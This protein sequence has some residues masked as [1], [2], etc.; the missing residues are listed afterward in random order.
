MNR[1]E[2]VETNGENHVAGW[3]QSA[4]GVRLWIDINGRG[5]PILLIH[6][7]TMSSIFWRRQERLANLF[8]LISIDMRGHGRSQSILRGHTVSRYARDVREVITTL[9]LDDAMLVGWSMGGSVVA[10]YWQQYGNDRVS[11]IGLVETCPYPMSSA[12]WNTHRYQ[13]QNLD[14]MRN[15]LAR[16]ALD[17]KTFGTNFINNMFLSGLAP[18]HALKWMQSEHLKVTDHTASSIYEDYAQ[19]DYTA[20]L[21]TITVPSLVIYGRSRHFCLGPSTGRFVA[22][23]IP[24]SRLVI[25]EKSGHLPFY[26]E[27]DAFN[28]ELIHFLN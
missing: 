13:G 17:R 26:E 25:L 3:V 1:F 20:V 19:R 15:D 27:A 4:D 14:A 12:P 2:A 11:R 21:P 28:N 9:G 7:W 16:M 23:S 22:G 5:H 10:D 24:D 8:Q 6:G 18:S